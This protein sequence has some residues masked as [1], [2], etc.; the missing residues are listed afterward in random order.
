MLLIGNALQAQVD[1]TIVSYDD[2]LAI[3]SDRPMHPLSDKS[4][5]LDTVE[6][7]Q[8]HLS[9]GT[10]LVGNSYSSASLFGISPS[11]V[12]QPNPRLRVKASLSALSSYSLAGPAGYSVRGYTPRSLAPLRYPANAL[13]ASLQLSAAYKLSDRLWIAASFLHMGGS[14]AAAAALNPW[15]S[16]DR[17]IPLNASAFTA[18]MR[19]RLSDDSYLHLHMT[20]IDDRT[21]AL[22]PL[23]FGSPY[24]S[25][26][27][28]DALTFGPHYGSPFGSSLLNSPW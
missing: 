1:D 17:P 24:G 23:L 11:V 12:Y 4:R 25:P 6:P 10:A 28:Y 14:L 9:M 21:G 8:F 13:A 5:L 2:R 27:Y 16:S 20:I 15:L 3:A 26:F 22:G 18:A 19:Y 7:W